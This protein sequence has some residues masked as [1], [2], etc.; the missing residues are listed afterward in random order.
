MLSRACVELMS[1]MGENKLDVENGLMPFAPK[2]SV[3]GFGLDMSLGEDVDADDWVDGDTEVPPSGAIS[4]TNGVAPVLK[5]LNL[6]SNVG[7]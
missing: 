5:A 2:R 6:G 4:P 7:G 1:I 3:G